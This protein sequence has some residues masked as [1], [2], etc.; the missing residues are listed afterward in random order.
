M[1]KVTVITDAAGKIVVIGKG[2]LSEKTARKTSA[3]G[4]P[5]GGLRAGPGQQLHELNVS[6]DLENIKTWSELHELV[7]PHVKV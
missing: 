6:E 5:Q 2:H 7:R 3:S 4:E 1:S